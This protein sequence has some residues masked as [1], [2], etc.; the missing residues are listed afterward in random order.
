[1]IY[2][3]TTLYNKLKFII[4]SF[5]L[6]PFIIFLV[7]SIPMIYEYQESATKKMVNDETT[8]L[9]GNTNYN[10]NMF[11]MLAR[12]LRADT[13]LT[14][15]IN[16]AII[17][18]K[19]SDY[20][21]FVF[22]TQ[23]LSALK[24]VSS[25]DQ[26]KAVRIYVDYPQ[27]RE[28]YPYLYK[29]EQASQCLWYEER[30]DLRYNGK[31]FLDVT[32]QMSEAT[33][34]GYFM[35]DDMA[36]FVIPIKIN[37]NVQGII[38]IVL[39]M[40]ALVR[41]LYE[42]DFEQDVI[43][44]DDKGN[45]H[46]KNRSS[47]WGNIEVNDILRIC[48]IS[49]MSDINMEGTKTVSTRL[50]HTPVVVSMMQN[51]SNDM[52][53]LKVVSWKK[54][55]MVIAF[56][57][58][59]I[60]ICGCCMVSIILFFINKI[61]QRLLNDFAIFRRC[62]NE[63]NNGNLEVEIPVLKQ[64][65]INEVAQE[66]NNMLTNVKQ[67]THDAIEKEIMIKDAQ[68]KALEKQID[69]HFLYNVLDSIKMM[70]EVRGI[71]DV[72]DALLALGKMFRYNLQIDNHDVT[73]REEI[74]YIENYLTLSNIRYDYYINLGEKIDDN[75]KD[76]RVPKMILQPI[77]ENAIIY[78]LDEMAEDTTIYL[79]AYIK[80]GYAYVELTDMGKGM[81]EEKVRRVRERIHK[82]EVCE[83]KRKNNGIG[84]KNIHRRIQ[85]MYGNECGV[86]VFSKECCYTKIILKIK[87]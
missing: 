7:A 75:V 19:M 83:E 39:P 36:S 12:T 24:I 85:L 59:C 71:K 52:L 22:K 9:F 20:E 81:S 13:F 44:I 2:D 73:L 60:I 46:G 1:M 10:M 50:N 65:E 6:I 55:Y 38:E 47:E 53:F 5:S 14:S 41:G 42:D 3:Q 48:K 82:G 33:Y 56:E 57:I 63:V 45:L 40:N 26:V 30:N 69:S 35:G 72:A 49:Q 74:S 23:T 15:E 18:N 28:Y 37:S 43:M 21:R 76:I 58:V 34:S 86:E 11:E 64:V 54:Q 77:V 66:Y 4:L 32:D 29:M 31:W 25:I 51:K 84:L 17:G 78:G 79:K 80:E 70:A 16:N 62:V 67:L 68:L 61:V 27:I 8:E 87:A